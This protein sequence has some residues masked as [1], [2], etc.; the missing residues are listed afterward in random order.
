MNALIRGT[1]HIDPKHLS[2][3]EWHEAWGQT[4]YYLEIVNQVKFE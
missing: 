4:K 3:D 2:E 1:L